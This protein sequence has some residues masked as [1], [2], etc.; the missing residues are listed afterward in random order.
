MKKFKWYYLYGVF[1]VMA[2]IL[3]IIAFTFDALTMLKLRSIFVAFIGIGML[4]KFFKQYRESKEV[5][6][7]DNGQ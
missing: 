3:P 5:K 4:T 2:L 6:E 1:G 7:N